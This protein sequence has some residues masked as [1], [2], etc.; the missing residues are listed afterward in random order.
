MVI[1]IFVSVLVNNKKKEFTF[2]NPPAV[3]LLP[4][5]SFSFPFVLLLRLIPPTLQTPCTTRLQFFTTA[6]HTQ[7]E[8]TTANQPPFCRQFTSTTPANTIAARTS[9]VSPLH[10]AHS[11]STSLSPL[12]RRCYKNPPKIASP[13][14][15]L[16]YLITLSRN[17]EF[18]SGRHEFRN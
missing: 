13:E 11:T 15:E 4:C 16:F 17:N 5:F 1:L 18:S 8:T 14:A 3:Y 7:F 10:S 12:Y 6:A 2:I 9:H